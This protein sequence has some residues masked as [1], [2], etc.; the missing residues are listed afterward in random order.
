MG[1]TVKFSCGGCDATAAG[2]RP[3]RNVFTSFSGRSY[4]FGT[5]RED[6][7]SEVAPEGWTAFDPYTQCCYCPA[8]M[9]SIEANVE[10]DLAAV[11]L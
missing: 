7:A 2:T 4:G 9:A 8:C 10:R 1:V 11:K 5:Y 6:L 3:L